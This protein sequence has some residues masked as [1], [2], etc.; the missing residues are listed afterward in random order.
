MTRSINSRMPAVMVALVLCCVA[1]CGTGPPSLADQAIPHVE[2]CINNY[3]TGHLNEAVQEC[4]TAIEV[5]SQTDSLAVAYSMRGHLHLVTD[6]IELAIQDYAKAVELDPDS[7]ADYFG[8]AQAY[9]KQEKWQK[10]IDDYTTALTHDPQLTMA[11]NGRGVAYSQIGEYELAV[12]DFTSA[13]EWEPKNPILFENRALAYWGLDQPALAVKDFETVLE[14]DPEHPN[15]EDISASIDILE[16]QTVLVAPSRELQEICIWFAD[17]QV[18]RAKLFT[19]AEKLMT[20]LQIH[21]GDAFISDDPVVLAELMQALEEYL[22]YQEEFIKTWEELGSVEGT[23]EFWNK[24]FESQKL[25]LDAFEKMVAGLR[26]DD[27]DLLLEGLETLERATEIGREGE[28][29][30]LEM[31]GKCIDQME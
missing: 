22:P 26:T 17:T 8:R 6:E 16:A 30:M 10:A 1:G 11:I 18:I 21:G 19:G 23:E 3:E 25:K 9:A 5:G 14:Y 31:R 20:V 2:A 15:A 12:E 24:E 28:N 29:A 4:T 27:E 13:I 7:A